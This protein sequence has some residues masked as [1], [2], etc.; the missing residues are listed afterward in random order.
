MCLIRSVSSLDLAFKEV[1]LL[2]TVCL[3]SSFQATFNPFVRRLSVLF[4][5][6]KYSLE[7]TVSNA[8]LY[9]LVSLAVLGF[10]A[11]DSLPRMGRS[12]KEGSFSNY[13]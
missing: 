7:Q 9:A 8:G 11:V 3:L 13:F 1:I 6:S 2:P 12:Q 4:S 5:T 10:I